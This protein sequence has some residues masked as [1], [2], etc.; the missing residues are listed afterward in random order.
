MKHR[1]CQKGKHRTLRRTGENVSY[2][3]K[4]LVMIKTRKNDSYRDNAILNLKPPFTEI[5]AF[6]ANVDQDQAAQNVQPDLESTL[7]AV[8]DHN[9][10]KIARYS[11]LSVLL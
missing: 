3:T 1:D 11:P 8:L 7:S 2:Q 10:Q 6:A 4:G 5:V 9:R